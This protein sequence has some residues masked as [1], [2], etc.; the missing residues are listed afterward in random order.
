[1]L[2]IAGI[3]PVKAEKYGSEVLRI[4]GERR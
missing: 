1:M 4:I 2:S 3:G